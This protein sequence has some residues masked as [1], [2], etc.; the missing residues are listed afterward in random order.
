MSGS[1]ASIWKGAFGVRRFGSFVA[2]QAIGGAA[3]IKGESRAVK[4]N[5]VREDGQ[6][7]IGDDGTE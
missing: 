7:A 4:E 1:G 5:W 2:M 3:M 6:R